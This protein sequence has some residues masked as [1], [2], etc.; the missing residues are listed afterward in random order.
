MTLCVGIE[1][2][3]KVWIG[4]DRAS[5]SED[6]TERAEEP[7]VWRSGRWLIAS[8]GSWRALSIARL[9]ARLP[10]PVDEFSIAIGVTTELQRALAAGNYEPEE[11]EDDRPRWLVAS[12]KLGLWRIDNCWHAAKVHEAAIGLSYYAH[13]WLDGSSLTDPELR[14][15]EC[16]KATARR[17][18]AAVSSG[19]LILTSP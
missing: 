7:K 16:I 19:S 8:A 18:P 9:T 15:R 10:E 3:G 5:V 11:D 4:A 13:G 6:W 14:I 12:A 17:F 1:R 2:R